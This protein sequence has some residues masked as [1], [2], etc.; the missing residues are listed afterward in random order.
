MFRLAWWTAAFEQMDAI[1]RSRP[2]RKAE[3]AVALREMSAAL[4]ANPEG[5]GESRAPPD[6]VWFFG[7]LTVTFRPVPD[8]R[9]VYVTNVWLHAAD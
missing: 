6:R 8:E 1:V 4:A 5:T 9:T 3:F 7:P 2:G